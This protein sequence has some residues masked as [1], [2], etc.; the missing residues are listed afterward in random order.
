LA[1]GIA[2]RLAGDRKMITVL[3]VGRGAA[4]IDGVHLS[5]IIYLERGLLKITSLE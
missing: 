2:S 3:G 1:G 5:E 4:S